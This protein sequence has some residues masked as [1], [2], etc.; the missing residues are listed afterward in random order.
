MAGGGACVAGGCA[1]HGVYMAGAMHGRR[2][3]MAGGM[4]GEGAC[5]VG[6]VCG[7]GA[8]MAYGQWAGGTHPTGMH[9]CFLFFWGGHAWHT[10]NEWVVHILLE[11]IL[12]SSFFWGGGVTCHSLKTIQQLKVGATPAAYL[13]LPSA[14]VAVVQQFCP[15]GGGRAGCVR[16]GAVHGRGGG[17]CQE[18]RPLQRTVCFLMECILVFTRNMNT[19][20]YKISVFIFIKLWNY[21]HI[22]SHIYSVML[23][24]SVMCESVCIIWCGFV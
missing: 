5:M 24:M 14:T 7:R 17:A 4:C 1:W 10:V 20:F 9:S 21:S 6:G 8:C 15:G 3:C 23:Q 19:Y 13:F 11:C 12:V 18:G 2:A 16:R 22:K